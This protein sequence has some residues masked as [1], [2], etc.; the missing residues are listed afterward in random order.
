MAGLLAC[1]G[2]SPEVLRSREWW[3]IRAVAAA[4]ERDPPVEPKKIFVPKLICRR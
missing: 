2:Y 4:E 3:R 1:A